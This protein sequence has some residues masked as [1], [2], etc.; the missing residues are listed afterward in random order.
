MRWA[1][2]GIVLGGRPYGESSVIAE[3][4][5]CEHGRAMGLVKG[6]RSRRIRP[7]LQTGHLLNVE[8]RAR[9]DEQLGVYTLELVR[10]SSL[11]VWDDARALAALT[12]MTALLQYL[13]ERDPHRRLYAAARGYLESAAEPGFAARLVRFELLLLDELGF[14]LELRS[15]AASGAVENL[16]YVS[17]KSGQAVS[18]E[19]GAPYR[20]KLMRL[21]EFLVRETGEAPAARDVADGFALT[22]YF[23]ERH[24]FEPEGRVMP[25]ARD[26]LIRS[27][28]RDAQAA[29]EPGQSG[30]AP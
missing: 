17:P 20:D 2:E 19:A 25:R 26:E 3:I 29:S 13:P 7:L 14:G 10:A 15:C 18:A 21:P 1:D 9:L 5:T 6:G 28:E 27:V 24:V 4:F 30:A 12:A 23:L 8:W 16:I 11:A 22:G